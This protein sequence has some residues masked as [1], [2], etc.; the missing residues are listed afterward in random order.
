[1]RKQ[2]R[3]RHGIQDAICRHAALAGHLDAPVHVVELPDGMGVGID[4][5]YATIAERFLMPPPVKV[6]APR[7]RIYFNRYA[8]FRAGLQDLVD[9]DLVSRTPLQLA[10]GHVSDD[11]GVRIPD[12]DALRLFL[13]R[14]FEPAVNARNHKIEVFRISSG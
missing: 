12:C 5:E 9:I 10:S 3:K 14:Q 1:M 6:E 11:C 2:F 13:L 4:A 8:V 7:M